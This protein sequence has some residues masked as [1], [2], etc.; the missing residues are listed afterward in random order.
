MCP[1]QPVIDRR[2]TRP[3]TQTHSIPSDFPCLSPPGI[4]PATSCSTLR[5]KFGATEPPLPLY[6]SATSATIWC[7]RAKQKK[8]TPLPPSPPFSAYFVHRTSIGAFG[9]SLLPNSP[10]SAPGHRSKE[11]TGHQPQY[12]SRKVPWPRKTFSPSSITRPRTR[13]R[14]RPRTATVLKS[15]LVTRHSITI[16]V[17]S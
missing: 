3:C 8:V 7:T 10:T 13:P 5:K 16:P 2:V 11:A 15:S 17:L 1:R 9:F 4:N 12:K 6:H 14:L